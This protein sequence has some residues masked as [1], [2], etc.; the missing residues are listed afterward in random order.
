MVVTRNKDYKV[1]ALLY[2]V[3]VVLFLL[4]LVF[5]M[6]LSVGLSFL[7]AMPFCILFILDLI[8][9]GRTFIMDED[10]CT[11]C[12]WKYRKKYLWNE[13][14]TKRIEKHS[15]PSIFKARYACPYLDEAIFSPFVIHKP[16]FMRAAGYSCFHPVS[17]IYVHFRVG[18]DNWNLGRYY[19]IEETVF[20]QKMEDWG[21][22]M[23]EK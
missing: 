5:A 7:F 14:K 8:S 22:E 19:E 20:R 2:I 17:C 13:L 3:F 10:G 21:I 6:N 4:I 18:T 1:I 9:T 15:I 12:F 23:E 11:V 16:R